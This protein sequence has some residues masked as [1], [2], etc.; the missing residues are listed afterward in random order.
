MCARRPREMVATNRRRRAEHCLAVQERLSSDTSTA[1][2]LVTWRWCAQEALCA[3]RRR[4]GAKASPNIL[5]ACGCCILQV[6]QVR[7]V[8]LA[9]PAQPSHLLLQICSDCCEMEQLAGEIVV[10]VDTRRRR[11]AGPV[12]DVGQWFVWNLH[13]LQCQH[14]GGGWRVLSVDSGVRTCGS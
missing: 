14:R 1:A 7:C 4:E 2:P 11:G 10:V 13:G 9:P 3:N 8:V 5:I 12:G 6:N